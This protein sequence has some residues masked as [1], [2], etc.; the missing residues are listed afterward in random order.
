[1]HFRNSLTCKRT[2][3]RRRYFGLMSPSTTDE[4]RGPCGRRLCARAEDAE[5]KGVSVIASTF[6][7]G[8]MVMNTPVV[9]KRKHNR[10]VALRLAKLKI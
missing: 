3:T 10:V 4:S 6:G 1:M 8:P 2:L 5:Q 7:I 9:I